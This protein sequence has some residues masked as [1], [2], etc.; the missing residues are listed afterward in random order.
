MEKFDWAVGA[1]HEQIDIIRRCS[2]DQLRQI[3]RSCDWAPET[4]TVLGWI[5]AQRCIDLSTALQVFMNAG[6]E[7]LN[8]VAKRHVETA[9]LGRARLLDNICLRINCGF[10]LPLPGSSAGCR[11]RVAQWVSYQTAGRHEGREGRWSL[12]E[13]ILQ[14]LLEESG[15]MVPLES[16]P[17]QPQKAGWRS[18]FM[19][20]AR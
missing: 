10:Y 5:M 20:P 1:V 4:E 11:A 13:K 14:S 7:R 18:M 15:R 17:P 2:E 6:P 3:A 8:Y 9:D 12:D 19:V 16:L